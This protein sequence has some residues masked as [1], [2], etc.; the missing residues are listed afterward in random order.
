MS[1]FTR[2]FPDPILRSRYVG[3]MAIL[4]C[5]EKIR[6]APLEYRYRLNV[7]ALRAKLKI[8]DGNPKARR[9]HVDHY[10]ETL[11]DPELADRLTLLRLAN[12]RKFSGTSQEQA[13]QIRVRVKIPTKA[14][15]S[16]AAAPAR[17][18][19]RAIQ[20]QDPSFE[21]EGVSGS[22]GSDS[23]SELLRTFLAATEEK[24]IRAG[25]TAQSQVTR[26]R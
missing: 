18:M 24:F 15:S 9:E 13:T 16:A 14:P 21:S 19:V 2:K 8:K 12:S 4:R 20:A 26:C 25:C 11:G 5:P 6:A 3:G 17:V 23:E 10:I 22:D 1:G 7:V